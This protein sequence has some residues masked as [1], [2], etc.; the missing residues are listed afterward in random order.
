MPDDGRLNQC[1]SWGAIKAK[2]VA[3]PLPIDGWMPSYLDDI[4]IGDLVTVCLMRPLVDSLGKPMTS[5]AR[6]TPFPIRAGVGI[7]A[8]VVGEDLE[9]DGALLIE[10]TG[11]SQRARQNAVLPPVLTRLSSVEMKAR[12]AW[13]YRHREE[14]PADRSGRTGA[15][16]LHDRLLQAA[17]GGAGD[18]L[19]VDRVA[20]C[21]APETTTGATPGTIG[22]IR[23]AMMLGGDVAPSETVID[24]LLA[25]PPIVR[26]KATPSKAPVRKTSAPAPVRAEGT[27]ERNGNYEDAAEDHLVNDGRM[28]DAH[29]SLRLNT[30]DYWP[31][32]KAA[33]PG[34]TDC[35][36]AMMIALWSEATTAGRDVSYSRTDTHYAGRNHRAVDDFIYTLAKVRKAA[37]DL[38]RHGLLADHFVQRPGVRN[39]QSTMRGSDALV[40]LVT[41]TLG[42]KPKLVPRLPRSPVVVRDADRQPIALRDTDALRRMVAR[43]DRLN[44]GIRSVSISHGAGACLTRIYHGSFHSG[45]RHYADGL[46]WQNMPRA[47]RLRLTIDGEQVVEW[48]Y[49]NNHAH[50]LYADAG[51]V[52][53]DDAYVIG[54]WPRE[55]TK[56]AFLTLV[57]AKNIDQAVAAIACKPEMAMVDVDPKTKR[58]REAARHL[59]EAISARHDPIRRAFNTA[60][61]GA[62]MTRDSAMAEDV[63]LRMQAKGVVV[64]PIYDAFLAPASK[65]ATLQEIMIAVANDHGVPAMGVER[66][67][68]A[69]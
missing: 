12:G 58:A 56:L 57:N 1:S 44:E 51:A 33:V 8:R 19:V 60:A 4:T 69:A 61:G 31:A 16:A 20:G 5:T 40:R 48:D 23:A 68:A 22:R 42:S 9:G 66:K 50:M 39:R 17:G 53:P 55:L 13:I 64:L 52:L 24:Q 63:M 54:N 49:Q 37:D 3:K 11:F 2:P 34:L 38:D 62:L 26:P 28:H 18:E 45:G 59:I 6:G 15:K 36:A 25:M 46:S 43:V 7:V 35:G 41:D 47:A 65:S 14:G 30:R 21:T 29:L 67:V 32:L 10:R 27:R